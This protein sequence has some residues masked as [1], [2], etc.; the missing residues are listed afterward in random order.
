M[1]DSTV[2]AQLVSI[3]RSAAKLPPT[4]VVTT[5]S[6]L[7]EDL[8]IDS[9]DLVGVFLCVQDEF[10]VTIDESEVPRLTRLGDLAAYIGQARTTQ[11]A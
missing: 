9:L 7:I 8:G 1:S 5:E 6:R 4:Q 3:V 2:V 11:A 10:G